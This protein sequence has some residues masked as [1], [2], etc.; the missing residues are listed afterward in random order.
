[1]RDPLFELYGKEAEFRLSGS[2][3]ARKGSDISIAAYG[4]MV[5]EA[6]AAAD[7]LAAEG[8]DA[9]VIDLYSIK[10][11]DMPG[12]LASISRT[13]ALLVAE[14]HQSRNGL[15]AFIGDS[16]ARAGVRVP[17]DHI[18]LEESFAESGDYRGVLETYGL[19][20]SHIE[21]V[22]WRLLEAK[23]DTR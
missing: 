2:S 8:V 6:L 18:G 11:L 16:L 10:P 13:G 1:M 21:A 17:Y 23:S 14:N 15:G 12:I 7:S 22:C 9:E 5:F 20:S 4:D 19:C 3:I